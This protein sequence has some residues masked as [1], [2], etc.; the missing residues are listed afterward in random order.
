[1]DASDTYHQRKKA[2][3]VLISHKD[4]EFVFPI[5]RWNSKVVRKR[6]RILGTHSKAGTTC[7]GVKISVEKFKAN[8]KSLNQQNPQM[9]LK[10][11]LTFG[12]SNVTSSIVITLNHEYN[13]MCRRKKH[14]LFLK[15]IDVTRSAHTDLDVMQE[16]KMDDYWNVDSCKHLS[17]SWRGF[18]KFT[19]LIEKLPK[20]Y[21]WSRRRLTMI[22]TKPLPDQ[23][24]YGQ[25]YGRKL[26]KLLRIERSRNEQKKNQSSTMLEECEKF[27]ISIQM[28]KST[29]QLSRMRRELAKNYLKHHESGCKAGNCIREEFQNNFQ[30]LVESTRQRD[31]E[32]N[33][34]SPKTMKITLQ[35]K[36]LLR[37][38]ILI[39]CTISFRCPK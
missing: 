14:S 19:L 32:R 18:T 27:T 20:G 33:L 6:L 5:R 8:R 17:D 22:Q 25:Q 9:T 15:Y 11:V 21:T 10:L 39:L 38:G 13:S 3:E 12:R 28:T 35:V 23:I 36:D 24:M 2:K 1:M 37:C 26:V 4:D 7:K 34:R 31:N 29:K 30:L 16:K